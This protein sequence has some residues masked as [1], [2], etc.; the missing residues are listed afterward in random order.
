VIKISVNE[1]FLSLQQ[2]YGDFFF[3]TSKQALKNKKYEFCT[4]KEIL[5]KPNK[6]KLG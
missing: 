2:E 3:S 6:L 4:K 5:K 1:H